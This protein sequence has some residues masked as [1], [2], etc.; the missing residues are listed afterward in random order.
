MPVQRGRRGAQFIG[1][2]FTIH[3]DPI[4]RNIVI[5]FPPLALAD[6]PALMLINL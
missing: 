6:A 2:L 5:V 3:N 1:L 4:G